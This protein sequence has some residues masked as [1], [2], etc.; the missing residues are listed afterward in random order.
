MIIATALSASILLASCAG[1]DA[2]DSPSNA[3]GPFRAEFNAEGFA[4]ILDVPPAA[5]DPEQ[6]APV[7]PRT[8]E[9][10]AADAEFMRVADY[11]N[12]VMDEVQALS[13]RLRRAEKDNF[14]DLYYDNDG[15]LGVVFQFL[16]D[17]SQT[18]RRYSRNPTFRGETVRWS[19]DELMAAAEFMWETFREERV[20][21]GTG[22]RPQEVTVEI[23]VSE[24]EFRELVR[25]KGVTI[26][27]Q[28]TLVF[29]AAP[30]VPINNPLRPAV[31]D[32]AVPA[33]VAPHI[34]IFP[35]HD[36][37]AGALNAINSR[38]KLVL[39]NGCF[40]AA[41]TDDALV[42]FPFGA[43]LFVDSD[44]YLAFGSGQSP[45]YARVGETVIFMG[46]I[47]EVTVPE[48]VEPIY[49]V[50]GPG[51]VIKI[52]GLAS[53]DASDRQQAVTDNANALR[54]LQSEYGLGEA[55]ARRAMAWLDRR[56]MANRQVTEDGIA[57]PPITAAMTID[58]PPR[59]VIDASECPTGSRLVSGLCRTPEGYLRPLPE[60]LAE[61]LEQDR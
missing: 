25:R 39:K 18:L 36:R 45:G 3:Q 38:V 32:E 19:Q 42:L 41:D 10:D 61:F 23:I 37:P 58:I 57:L 29:H 44:N 6:P 59:P 14:V 60:W 54:R 7:Q 31:G 26:P 5:F 16:R 34:R 4:T 49:A 22:I 46:S 40:R 43:R 53:A 56:Q 21:Q 48:L 50:C 12:S 17:G 47:N 30:M 20:I 1:H 55:Q 52:E 28:V 51:K 11:Q 27:E 8:P 15:E 13:E 35:R 33:A 24:R 2:E 9:Q